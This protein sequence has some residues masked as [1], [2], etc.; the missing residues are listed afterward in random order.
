M[1]RPRNFWLVGAALTCALGATTAAAQP[2]GTS[3]T[4][5]TDASAAS[6]WTDQGFVDDVADALPALT[7]SAFNH[8]RVDVSTRTVTVSLHA[9]SQSVLTAVADRFGSSVKVEMA[10]NSLSSITSAWKS[11]E[12][13]VASWSAKGID[14][15]HIADTPDG[16]LEVGVAT[17]PEVAQQAFNA[18]VGPGLVRVVSDE[19]SMVMDTYRDNDVPPWN[20]G[21]LI[22]APDTPTKPNGHSECTAGFPLINDS[23]GNVMLLTAAHCFFSGSNGDQIYNGYI[24]CLDNYTDCNTSVIEPRGTAASAHIGQCCNH[25]QDQSL[26]GSHD[27]GTILASVS[28]L[29]FIGA[30]NDPYTDI[31]E[32]SVVNHDG[33]VVCVSGGFDGERCGL[34]E[35]GAPQTRCLPPARSICLDDVVQVQR[36]DHHWVGGNGDS[37]APVYSYDPANSYLN[38]RGMWEA[39]YYFDPSDQAQHVCPAG[40]LQQSVRDC[41]TI[42]YFIDLRSIM[43]MWNLHVRP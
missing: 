10:A 2:S 21:D 30:W 19:S 41:G 4:V 35:Q 22:A 12:G 29:D 15:R 23:T 13:D 6:L 5:S 42:G 31:Q 37:G 9:A 16:Y 43:D 36:S 24:K 8:V 3:H 1:S 38:P 26:N 39:H 20:G 40:S 34:I 11:I 27:A 32:S 7:G 25:Y 33:D 14:I 18:A 17:E 28:H